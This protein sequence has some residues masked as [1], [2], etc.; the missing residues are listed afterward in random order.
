MQGGVY[1]ARTGVGTPRTPTQ[2]GGVDDAITGCGLYWRLL[3]LTSYPGAAQPLP[4]ITLFLLH[5]FTHSFA[6]VSLSGERD[7]RLLEHPQPV[8]VLLN[9]HA[10]GRDS[11][12]GLPHRRGVVE[13][14][15]WERSLDG[16]SRLLGVVVRDLKTAPPTPAES[17]RRQVAA[18]SWYQLW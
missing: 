5:P 10:L 6:R 11:Q 18:A 4:V 9:T 14:Q 2:R 15:L 12:R 8:L 13:V 17:E 1:D 16:R 3:P 7:L